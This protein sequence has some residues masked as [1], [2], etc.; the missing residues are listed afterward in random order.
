MGASGA[1]ISAPAAIVS[2]GTGAGPERRAPLCLA[3]P[4]RLPSRAV[5]RA[6]AL[7]CA[8]Q[9]ATGPSSAWGDRAS[10]V[11]PRPP[12]APRIAA[13]RSLLS[14]ALAV[15]RPRRGGDDA[16]PGRGLR[17]RRLR[18]AKHLPEPHGPALALLLERARLFG[19]PRGAAAR[20]LLP[21]KERAGGEGAHAEDHGEAEAHG[22][23]GEVH[24]RPAPE[25]APPGLVD[26]P[27]AL[28][29]ALE[30]AP[31]LARIVCRQ[32]AVLIVGLLLVAR[33]RATGAVPEDAGVAV[34]AEAGAV[35]ARAGRRRGAAHAVHGALVGAKAVARGDRAGAAHLR[36]G[37]RG[38]PRGPITGL[39]RPAADAL[40]S[41]VAGPRVAAEPRGAKL[42]VRAR[43]VAGCL[44]AAVLLVPAAEAALAVVVL[45]ARLPG[46][47]LVRGVEL[48][49]ADAVLAGAVR[50]VVAAIVRGTQC[51]VGRGL[52]R[53]GLALGG[54]RTHVLAVVGEVCVLAG[55]ACLELS[56]A[57]GLAREPHAGVVRLALV[58]VRRGAASVEGAAPAAADALLAK[59]V[60]VAV[61]TGHVDAGV[62]GVVQE[63]EEVPRDGEVGGD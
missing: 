43:V 54:G 34:A 4:Q 30:R 57:A 55:G 40:G 21:A 22:A 6:S 29:D 45:I 8:H 27:Q 32:E 12:S 61:G 7:M 15:D 13:A 35:G 39:H 2:A 41:G 62:V 49:D 46:A 28:H 9:R 1:R 25:R 18:E 48:A 36:V 53:A 58:H 11:P 44:L 16:A 63:R 31:A 52:A 47:L 59:A 3:P 20:H 5:C 50:E 56:A 38:G 37:H 33:A 51:P 19:L 23:Q 24:R 42:R 14:G 10:A 26:D 60:N 17:R